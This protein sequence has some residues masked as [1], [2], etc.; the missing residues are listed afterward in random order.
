MTQH[1]LA[2]LLAAKGSLIESVMAAWDMMQ[3]HAGT[4]GL[5]PACV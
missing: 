4:G 3:E 1:C 2:E 5:H